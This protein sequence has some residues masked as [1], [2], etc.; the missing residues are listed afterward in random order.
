MAKEQY[1]QKRII[2]WFIKIGGT[3]IT[4]T[5][6]TGEADI[7]AGYPYN[8]GVKQVLLNV[9]V[10]VKTE[11]DYH[12]V[13]RCITEIDGLYVIDKSCGSLKKHETLQII[14]LNNVR[15]KGGMALLAY[16]VAQVIEYIDK[17]TQ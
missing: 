4:G 9:M 17:E 10:E 6:P 5:L 13:M 3:A 14:K 15:K 7:Q 12:R 2:D 1:Y 11:F 16:S 8:I